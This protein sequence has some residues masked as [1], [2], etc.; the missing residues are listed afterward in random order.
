MLESTLEEE[1]EEPELVSSL[2]EL[3]EDADV[4]E[5]LVLVLLL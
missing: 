2:L 1:A 3:H 5:L 4:P